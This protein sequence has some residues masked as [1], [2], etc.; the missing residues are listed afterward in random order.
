MAI[1]IYNYVDCWYHNMDGRYAKI[2]I[3]KEYFDI[4]EL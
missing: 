3:I 2:Q 1:T 4:M